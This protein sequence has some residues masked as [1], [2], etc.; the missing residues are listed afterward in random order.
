MQSCSSS[1]CF[2]SIVNLKLQIVLNW[3]HSVVILFEKQEDK[4]AVIWR[5]S[6]SEPKDCFPQY[7]NWCWELLMSLHHYTAVKVRV[8]L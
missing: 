7:F 3:H 8:V 4:A 6:L 1:A 5:N 2:D